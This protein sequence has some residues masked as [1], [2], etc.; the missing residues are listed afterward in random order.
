MRVDLAAAHRLA[1]MDD[2]HEGSWNHMSVVI[3][4]ER[5][6]LLMTPAD[7]HWSEVTATGLVE[8]GP[9][10]TDRLRE[11]YD[12]LWV[13]YR[14][15]YPVHAARGDAIC[16]IH[17]HPPHATALSALADGQLEF[18]DQAALEFYERIAYSDVYDGGGG[19]GMDQGAAIAQWLGD[20]ATVLFLRNHGIVVIGDSIAAAYTDTYLLERAC[21]VQL[22]AMASGRP[23]APVPADAARAMRSEGESLSYRV[24]HFAAMKRVLVREGSDYAS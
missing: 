12:G 3:P 9:E 4:G 14:I 1:V 11:T 23:L 6:R 16:M 20:H 24:R 2:L 18:V 5:D 21:R 22:L 7:T 8:V 17:L 10:D 19:F 15:H 13:A